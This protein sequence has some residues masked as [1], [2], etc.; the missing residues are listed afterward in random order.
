MKEDK[1][2]LR[3]EFEELVNAGIAAIPKNFL[4]LLDNVAIILK[5]KHTTH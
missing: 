2:M 4:D 5:E 1:N 3:K